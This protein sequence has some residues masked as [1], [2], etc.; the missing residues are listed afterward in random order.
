[1]NTV[2]LTE[3]EQLLKNA[4]KD[5][6]DQQLAPR[7]ADLDQSQAF[8]WDNVK[9][10]ADMGP[11]EGLPLQQNHGQALTRHHGGDGA[12]PGSAA[13]DHNVGA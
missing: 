8:P 11:G 3:E 13:N 7:A 2:L 4:V 12:A 10:L 6:A 9:G 1:M 5:F